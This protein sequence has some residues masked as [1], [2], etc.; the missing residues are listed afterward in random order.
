MVG[1]GTSGPNDQK[2][3]AEA[4]AAQ[5][6]VSEKTIRRDG[7]KAEAYANLVEVNAD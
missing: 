5:H 7:K 1:I 4:L 2:S 3:T 6:G